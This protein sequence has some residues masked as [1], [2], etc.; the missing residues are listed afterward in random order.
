MISQTQGTEEEIDG[1]DLLNIRGHYQDSG[2]ANY[3]VEEI[4]CKSNIR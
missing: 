2:M 3:S 1:L 4:I